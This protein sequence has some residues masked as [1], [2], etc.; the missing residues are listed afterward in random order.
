MPRR[1]YKPR[2]SADR[3]ALAALNIDVAQRASV[4][5]A[6]DSHLK[7][8]LFPCM[9]YDDVIQEGRVALCQAAQDWDFRAGSFSGFAYTRAYFRVRDWIRRVGPVERG[10]GG[11]P[12]RQRLNVT[13]MPWVDAWGDDDNKY[14]EPTE[15]QMKRWDLEMSAEEKVERVA[16]LVAILRPLPDRERLILFRL[17]GEGKFMR[18]IARELKVSESRISQIATRALGRLALFAEKG[19]IDVD[20]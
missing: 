18:E 10:R 20:I 7:I 9:E 6:Y 17:Y 12:G 3:A 2:L 19:V 14:K 13:A 15:A 8:G 5:A 4:R 11:V 1:Q 16:W